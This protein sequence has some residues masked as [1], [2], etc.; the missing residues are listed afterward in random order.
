MQSMYEICEYSHPLDIRIF[1]HKV[2]SFAMHW[3]TAYEFL[4]ILDG[5][6]EVTTGTVK[7]Y[8]EGD[9]LLINAY[10]PHSLLSK[11]G[12]VILAL[13]VRN[14]VF[15][16]DG[17][18][19]IDSV[20]NS[21][22]DYSMIKSIMARLIKL[23][24]EKA[25]YCDVLMQSLVLRLKYEI[26]SKFRSDSA[27][28]EKFITYKKHISKLSGVLDYIQ[29]NY[30]TEISLT[31]TANEFFFSAAYLSRL[32]EKTMGITFKKYID[33]LRFTEAMG[34]LLSTDMSIDDV[35]EKSGFP[36]TRAFVS[37]HKETYGCLPSE[38]RKNRNIGDFALSEKSMNYVDFKKTDYL[39]KL[40]KYLSDSENIATLPERSDISSF[41]FSFDASNTSVKLKHTFK[42]FCT[43]GRASDLL[44]ENIRQMLRQAQKDIGFKYI[45]FHGLFDDDLSVYT[46]SSDGTSIINFE[47]IDRILDFLLSINLKPLL[48]LS[49]MPK[50]LAKY[51]EKT[52][53]FR[54]L[55]TSEP[56]SNEEW[57]EF[58]KTFTRHILSRY[59]SD[60]AE[61][62]LFSVWNEAET[63]QNMFGFR[64]PSLFPGFY[65]AT[66]KAVKEVFPE[67]KFGTTSVMYETL[68]YHDWFDKMAKELSDC[69]P[70][71]V[72]LHFY[73]VKT[74]VTYDIDHLSSNSIELHS[75][76]YILGETITKVKEKLESLGYSDLPVYL[77]EWNSTTSHR[78]L[79]ND[80]A[81]KGPYVAR[82]IMA[83]FDR[84]DS[85]GYWS[86][87]DDIYELPAD[88][89]LFHG[90]HG[91]F[92]K[93]GI[94][95]PPYYAFE[96]LAKLGHT[97]IGKEKGVIA[98]KNSSGF[99]FVFANYIH[100]N[101]LYAAG[102][103]FDTNDKNRYS[104]FRSE[105][106]KNFDITLQNVADGEYIA[107][108][109]IVNREYGS[110]YDI[111]DRCFGGEE[112]RTKQAEEALR[113]A[114]VPNFR[115]QKLSAVGGNL[116][117]KVSLMPH[118]IRLAVIKKI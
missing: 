28:A 9:L 110:V 58:I 12:A 92:T 98:T 47:N 75:N 6:C 8:R 72:N 112:P 57:G 88:D 74:S 19:N 20:R 103:L 35:A 34:L 67:A 85:F 4:L 78:D 50:E 11:E 81:F 40:A 5:E 60:E 91:L 63:P 42:N 26:V 23:H 65:R 55:I 30:H 41:E 44:R 69:P 107:E 56:K 43:V 117:F 68:L 116:C 99:Q 118:E 10:E 76:P 93:N 51:P 29:N 95:K 32:F 18:F 53:F 15:G 82:N 114:A 14:N 84:L 71:F 37:M 105:Q 49:F 73:P 62:W 38:H 108:E 25:P 52:A 16:D 64:D 24:S 61:K 102:E 83:N 97:L 39:A 17:G 59:G 45:K 109:Y 27:D 33:S 46:K 2:D 111:W 96:F 48:Q 86:L 21:G 66:Y 70:D 80:T 100:Y 89:R 3:H 90:G 104:A 54:P 115:M 79:L 106:I 87:T 113:A 77:T 94:K 7:K 31:K 101:E 13:Q 1:L 36:N 22:A